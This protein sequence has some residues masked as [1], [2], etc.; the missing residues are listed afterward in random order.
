LPRD[1]A[2]R[3]LI[4]IGIVALPELIAVLT[5]DNLFK[6]EQAIDAIG[7]ISYYSKN[8]SALPKMLCLYD[9]HKDS[10]M[11]LWKLI[12]SFSAFDDSHV[13]SLLDD[14]LLNHCAPSIRW[15]AARSLGMIGNSKSLTP[16][17]KAKNDSHP[18]VIKMVT[19]AI[20]NIQKMLT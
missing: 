11:I 14:C 7:F 1:I 3:V 19:L 6:T 9:K 13:F 20:A 18:E 5:E 8:S 12:R 16:L 4:R 2:A 15:E 17:N 10:E